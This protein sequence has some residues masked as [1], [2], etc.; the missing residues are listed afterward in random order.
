MRQVSHCIYW[1]PNIIHWIYHVI[2]WIANTRLIHPPVWQP[3]ACLTLV[4]RKWLLITPCT[5]ICCRSIH[6]AMKMWRSF[7]SSER[8]NLGHK[9]ICKAKCVKPN[10]KSYHCHIQFIIALYGR[11]NTGQYIRQYNGPF[12]RYAYVMKKLNWCSRPSHA[13]CRTFL[14]EIEA[15]TRKNLRKAKKNKKTLDKSRKNL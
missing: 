15:T 13:S 4:L 7:L 5:C 10:S 6:S 14:R 12:T 9:T 2:C 3:G 1:L 11:Q 8:L